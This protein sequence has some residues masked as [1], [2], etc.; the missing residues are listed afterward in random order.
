VQRVGAIYSKVKQMHA[1]SAIKWHLFLYRYLLP[2]RFQRSYLEKSYRNL[3]ITHPNFENLRLVIGDLA[4]IELMKKRT[5]KSLIANID[6]D[7]AAIAM[8]QQIIYYVFSAFWYRKIVLICTDLNLPLFL[9]LKKEWSKCFI[10]RGFRINS[11]LCSAI[12]S[13]FIFIF[14]IRSITNFLKLLLFKWQTTD[15]D[16]NSKNISFKYFY[17]FPD[18]A[19]VS[20]NHSTNSN[21]LNWFLL[22]SKEEFTILCSNNL[23][24]RNV[25]GNTNLFGKKN[26][27]LEFRLLKILTKK[28]LDHFIHRNFKFLFL[29]LIYINEVS[30]AIRVHLYQSKLPYQEVIFNASL[31]YARPLWSVAMNKIDIKS[32]LYFYS[33]NSSPLS[34]DFLNAFDDG[35]QLNNWE[36]IF[37][38]D[39]HQ[40]DSIKIASH[41]LSDIEVLNS[42]PMWT[43]LGTSINVLPEDYILVFDNNVNL[44]N[45]NF[46][47][48]AANGA[49]SMM[50]IENFLIDVLQVSRNLSI[51]IVYKRKRP[52]K[53]SKNREFENFLD[54][55]NQTNVGSLNVLSDDIAPHKLIQ[56]ARFVIGKPMS[57]TLLIAK[58][59][60]INCAYYD[61]TR[62]VNESDPEA[63]GIKIVYSRLELEK[64]ICEIKY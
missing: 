37:A 22:E 14:L 52:S 31:A 61:L 33:N 56:R 6:Y 50:N 10:Q 55:L 7:E 54:E 9:P 34:G 30:K 4:K 17:D 26:F 19:L 39:K 23:T 29:I 35:W 15:F 47:F 38:L 64:L 44:H 59:Q 2:S 53:S 60:G 42:I 25:T 41:N 3:S 28:L 21:F 36:Y 46:G 27:I 45:Y 16:L 1:M 5:N 24:G 63:R 51:P 32:K 13:L 8:N 18:S 49:D 12:W 58:E 57:T 40:A 11:N 20:T 62:S 43:D 48:L